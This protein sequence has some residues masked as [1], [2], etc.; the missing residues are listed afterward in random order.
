MALGLTQPLT[1]MS[2]R[3]ISWGGKGGRCVGLATLPP[4]SADCLEILEFLTPGNLRTCSGINGVDLP[5]IC[6]LNGTLTGTYLSD[7]YRLPLPDRVGHG[8]RIREST[9]SD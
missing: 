8:N 4:L 7:K 3:R 1:E 9:G 6:P 2:T 5:N